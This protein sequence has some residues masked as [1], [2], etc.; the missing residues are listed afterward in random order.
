MTIS[1]CFKD[2][3]HKQGISKLIELQ[4]LSS[5]MHITS[6]ILQVVSL[7][8]NCGNKKKSK[9]LSANKNSSYATYSNFR[10][11]R[12]RHLLHVYKLYRS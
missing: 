9:M 1:A 8:L 11:H 2:T 12:M 6:K 5:R 10:S 3:M 4:S 7:S